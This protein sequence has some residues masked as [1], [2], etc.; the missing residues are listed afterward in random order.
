MM[1]VMQR[2]SGLLA[3]TDKPERPP[4][5]PEHPARQVIRDALSKLA[6]DLGEDAWKGMR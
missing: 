1:N 4:K 6:N 3:V 2:Q 5:P